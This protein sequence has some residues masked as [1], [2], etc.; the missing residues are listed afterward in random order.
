[1]AKW[2]TALAG[3]S[4]SVSGLTDSVHHYQRSLSEIAPP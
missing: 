2:R 1:L 3:L 4:T